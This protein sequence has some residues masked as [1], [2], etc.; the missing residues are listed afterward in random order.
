MEVEFHGFG[1]IGHIDGFQP[2]LLHDA[3]PDLRKISF[4]KRAASPGAE[5]ER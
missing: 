1:D 3:I 2:R 5:D 4:L